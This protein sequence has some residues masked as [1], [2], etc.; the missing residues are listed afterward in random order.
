MWTLGPEREPSGRVASAFYCWAICLVPYYWILQS[1]FI[2]WSQSSKNCKLRISTMKPRCLSPS[3]TPENLINLGITKL[4]PLCFLPISWLNHLY[5][6][7]ECLV[8]QTWKLYSIYEKKC[9]NSYKPAD[10]FFLQIK[11]LLVI[12]GTFFHVSWTR[13]LYLASF[14]IMK[15]PNHWDINKWDFTTLRTP[16]W[17]KICLQQ[18]VLGHLSIIHPLNQSRYSGECT[19]TCTRT[20]RSDTW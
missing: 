2:P 8:L 1:G 14:P 7:A 4:Y 10:F 15:V 12:L 11:I 16:V 6:P 3:G 13:S 20:L 17:W 5:D 9:P 19:R 18:E